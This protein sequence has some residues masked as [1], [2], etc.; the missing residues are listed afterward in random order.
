[1]NSDAAA[2]RLLSTI[3]QTID[4][5][6]VGVASLNVG[7]ASSL[8]PIAEL[9]DVAITWAA[10]N[11]NRIDATATASGR[12]WWIAVTIEGN[13]ATSAGATERPE[14]FGGVEDGR[15][16]VLNGPSSVGNSTVMNAI[17]ERA[18]TPWI[19]SANDSEVVARIRDAVPTLVVG[20]DCPLGTLVARQ[21]KRLD[22]WGGL[23][24][25]TQDVHDGWSYDLRFD[26]SRLEVAA[27]ADEIIAACV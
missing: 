5:K 3:L 21:A 20:L 12:E 10:R 17:V 27:V 23:T 22:R 8:Q 11:Q 4:A 13:T 26:T 6:A 14:M 7:V 2:L 9:D 15:A 16:V 1:M 24:E 18:T 19:I 25:S